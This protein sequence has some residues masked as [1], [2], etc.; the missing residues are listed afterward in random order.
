ME[1]GRCQRV[2]RAVVLAIAYFATGLCFCLPG[3]TLVQ[4]AE[5]TNSNYS[6]LSYIFAARSSGELL[7]TFIG[8]PFL[9]EDKAVAILM[10]SLALAAVSLVAVPWCFSLPLLIL[11]TTATGVALG[12]AKRVSTKL[13]SESTVRNLRLLILLG[14]CSCPVLV[15]IVIQVGGRESLRTAY[16]ASAV[17]L[18]T[19]VLLCVPFLNCRKTHACLEEVPETTEV[20]ESQPQPHRAE[21]KLTEVYLTRAL[22]LTALFLTSGSHLAMGQLLSAFSAI[23]SGSGL[24]EVNSRLVTC[25]FYGAALVVNAVAGVYRAP[26]WMIVVIQLGAVLGATLLT[27]LPTLWAVQWVA[28]GLMGSSLTAALTFEPSPSLDATR[29]IP[30]LRGTVESVG[31]M[32]VCLL[33]GATLD[34]ADPRT[35]GTRM[36]VLVALSVTLLLVLWVTVRR[37]ADVDTDQQC[38]TVTRQAAAA[39]TVSG[40]RRAATTKWYVQEGEPSINQM[41]ARHS[42]APGS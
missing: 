19:A 17:L 6:R 33:L 37:R 24:I 42:T 34:D 9:T 29:K 3:P 31:E 16:Y 23:F 38:E 30:T 12:A 18:A 41:A 40:A 14:A 21:S 4:L 8:E 22:G 20:R 1:D 7:G 36:C 32:F 10:A 25:F 39:V 5:Q 2:A 35:F 28:A 26:P 13:G 11:T 15:V 27:S